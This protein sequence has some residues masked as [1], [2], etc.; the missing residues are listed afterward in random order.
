MEH[1]LSAILA[2][3]VVGYSHLMELD[4]AETLASLKS[5]VKT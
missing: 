2:V 5:T 3:D 4:E 1:R